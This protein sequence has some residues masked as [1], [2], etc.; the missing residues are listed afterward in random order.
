MWLISGGSASA[1]NF[2]TTDSAQSLDA[3]ECLPQL[4]VVTLARTPT[5]LV[6][7]PSNQAVCTITSDT[8]APSGG[9]SV[10]LTLPA[11]SGRYSTDCTDPITIAAA[12]TTATCTIVATP[13]TVAGDGS[14]NAIMSLTTP[15][16][17]SPYTLGTPASATITVNDDDRAGAVSAV[18]TLSS[19][20]LSL[21]G[22]VLAGVRVS[23]AVVRD[24]SGR[25]EIKANG[26]PVPVHQ[27]LIALVSKVINA[28][29]RGSLSKVPRG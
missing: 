29:I 10:A 17:T 2:T 9:L 13:D 21:L 26:V 16:A 27:A 8:A 15:S 11:A 4:P 18:P 12:S 22:L 7:S 14:V 3:T 24:A 25:Q 5:A 1:P 6:E 20:A 28:D 19:W 23:T